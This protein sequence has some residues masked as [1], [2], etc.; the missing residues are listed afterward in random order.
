ML[1]ILCLRV[2]DGVFHAG[3]I[4]VDWVILSYECVTRYDVRELSLGSWRK[5]A[6]LELGGIDWFSF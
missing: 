6:T 5:F 4:F 3:D 2:Y 1:V